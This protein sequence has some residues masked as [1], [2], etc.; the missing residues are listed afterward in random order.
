MSCPTS[1]V[2][3]VERFDDKW[4]RLNNLYYITNEDGQKVKFVCNPLQEKLYWDLWY[5]NLILKARQFGGTTFVDIF[6]LDDC[7]FIKDIEAGIIAHNREDASKIFRR[8]VKFPYDNLPEGFRNQRRLVTDSQ[9]ELAFSNGSIIYVATSVRSG[10]V[11]RLHISEHG[12]ICRKYPDKAQEIK[13]GSLNAIHAGNIVVIESTAE[14]RYGDFFDFCTEALNNER[15]EKPL[16]KLD[17][18]LHFFPWFWDPKNQLDAADALLVTLPKESVEYFDK[19]EADGHLIGTDGKPVKLTRRQKTW[20]YKKRLI[21]KEK[22]YQEFPSTPAEAFKASIEGAYYAE[23]M[24]YLR[25]HGRI[26]KVPYDPTLPV[27]TAWDLGIDDWMVLLFHQRYGMENRIID[28]YYG[29]DRKLADYVQMLQI[30]G[31]VYNTH[32]LPH[33]IANK[34]LIT[35]KTRLATLIELMPDQ[36]I[37]VVDKLDL[38]DGISATRDFLPSCWIDEEKCEKFIDGMDSYQRKPDEINGGYFDTPLHNWATHF[39]DAG[40]YLAI[41]Y[42]SPPARRKKRRSRKR[43]ARVV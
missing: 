30:K 25:E 1:Q 37:V 14:G 24:A 5:C 29:N 6:F 20:Y 33:D 22:M 27:N 4:W 2:E 32:F 23:E 34:S 3:V 42:Q 13:T 8:K 10:T 31:Y 12:K 39:A 11:Q 19:L 15:M 40:R 38:A 21:M 41:G 16:T 17:Y 9:R 36:N 43:S 35:G 28:L 26:G 7:L 18:K